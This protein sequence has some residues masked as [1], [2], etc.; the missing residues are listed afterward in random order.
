M[1]R[2]GALVGAVATATAL[3]LARSVQANSVPVTHEI[4]I[5]DFKF[6]PEQ[7]EVKTGDTIRWINDDLAPHTATAHE[8][9]WD[10][11]EIGGGDV[12]EILVTSDMEPAYFC[13]FHPH[14]V[15]SLIIV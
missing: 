14:M 8:Y 4:R 15:A 2:R 11:G 13:A 5:K 10:T 12:A 7:I 3:T 1:T 6:S 9:S